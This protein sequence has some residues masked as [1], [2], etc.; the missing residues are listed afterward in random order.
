VRNLAVVWGIAA[1]L[2]AATAPAQEP[3]Q[4]LSQSR[5]KRR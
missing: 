5:E 1:I 4:M 3:G 2:F